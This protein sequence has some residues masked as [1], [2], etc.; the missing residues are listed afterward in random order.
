MF[1]QT[2]TLFNYK[3]SDHS[4][5]TS[6]FD[7]VNVVEAQG[8]T[9]TKHGDNNSDNVEI[10]LNCKPSKTATDSEGNKLQYVAPKTYAAQED[11]TGYFTLTPECDFIMIGDHGEDDPVDDDDYDEGLYHAMNDECD[12]VYMITGAT[13]FGLLPHFEIGGR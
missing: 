13:W 11:V 5:H 1:D 4:W 6:V 12:G 10:L 8:K 7:G 9:A 3:E 2:I